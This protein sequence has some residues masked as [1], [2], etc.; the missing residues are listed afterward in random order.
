MR[1]KFLYTTR[2]NILSQAAI[3]QGRDYVAEFGRR[4]GGKLARGIAYDGLMMAFLNEKGEVI[5]RAKPS[6]SAPKLE[7]WLIGLGG[8]VVTPDDFVARLGPAS[9]LAQEM[10]GQL[11]DT[12]ASFPLLQYRYRL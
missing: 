7:S 9:S 11:W 10:V 12:F 5:E 2:S 1:W 4:H 6:K 8:E 3:A